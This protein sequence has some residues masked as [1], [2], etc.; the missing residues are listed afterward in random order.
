M[1]DIAKKL[2][3]VYA[4]MQMKHTPRH[5]VSQSPVEEDFKSYL[6]DISRAILAEY[7][8]RRQKEKKL[9]ACL[10]Q[11]KTL[12]QGLQSE[13]KILEEAVITRRMSRSK[14][15]DSVVQHLA[16][17]ACEKNQERSM[18]Q[19]GANFSGQNIITPNPKNVENILQQGNKSSLPSD[20]LKTPSKET[21]KLVGH[22]AREERRSDVQES[23]HCTESESLSSLKVEPQRHFSFLR[24]FVKKIL[25]CF[26]VVAFMAVITVCFYDFLRG[27]LLNFMI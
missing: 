18:L 27:A 2:R 4:Q 12:V 13:K 5:S 25:P 14:S 6:D 26:L 22:S 17:M 1:S 10:E 23:G 19:E 7:S 21:V 11:I 3:S 15:S 9:F 20:V 24:F 16:H 8:M